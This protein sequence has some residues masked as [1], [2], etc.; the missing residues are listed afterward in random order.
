[1][2]TY[3]TQVFS[4]RFPTGM[5]ILT[6]WMLLWRD[7]ERIGVMVLFVAVAWAFLHEAVLAYGT[8]EG[9][10]RGSP[11]KFLLL[12]GFWILMLY[13]SYRNLL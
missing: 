9:A 4:A 11:L 2:I 5:L 8:V 13:V 1:M 6:G 3:L 7:R 12:L 10:P